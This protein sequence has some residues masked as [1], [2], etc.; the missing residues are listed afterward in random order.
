[1]VGTVHS[2]QDWADNENVAASLAG[3]AKTK[4]I[5]VKVESFRVLRLARDLT[6]GPTAAS[7]TGL[8]DTRTNDSG[9]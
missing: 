1:V 4:P 9:R 5:V 2:S 7:A 3:A 6:V 8:E